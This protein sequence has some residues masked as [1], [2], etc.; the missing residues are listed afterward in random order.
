[1]EKSQADK[2]NFERG[3]IRTLVKIPFY[4]EGGEELLGD[5]EFLRVVGKEEL[6]E[7]G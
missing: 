2:F 5:K 1:M 4:I 7:V 6:H 3:L